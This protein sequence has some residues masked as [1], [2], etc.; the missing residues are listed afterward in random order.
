MEQSDGQ[1]D[2]VR[3][4]SR[5]TLGACESYLLIAYVSSV[6]VRMEQKEVEI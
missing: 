1:G 4:V 3:E 5:C 6:R 2:D